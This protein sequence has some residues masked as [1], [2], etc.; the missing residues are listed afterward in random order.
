MDLEGDRR[1]PDAADDVSA[2]RQDRP[3]VEKHACA[4]DRPDETVEVPPRGVGEGRAASET[5]VAALVPTIDAV[6]MASLP[7]GR[8][9][10]LADD[11][12]ERLPVRRP[13][14]STGDPAI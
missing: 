13:C 2:A 8:A 6:V 4:V 12:K 11:L 3:I 9:G 1:Y 10:K 14:P 7:S 5:T